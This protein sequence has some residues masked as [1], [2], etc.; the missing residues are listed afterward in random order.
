M[1][2][3]LVVLRATHARIIPGHTPCQY[4]SS[5]PLART[6][7]PHPSPL[8]ARHSPLTTHPIT[9]HPH[10]SQLAG[11]SDHS[12]MLE[13]NRFLDDIK[14]KGGRLAEQGRSAANKYRMGRNDGDESDEEESDDEEGGAEDPAAKRRLRDRERRRAAAGAAAKSVVN[15]GGRR[16]SKGVKVIMEDGVDEPTRGGR[17]RGGGGKLKESHRAPGKGGGRGKSKGARRRADSDSDSDSDSSGEGDSDSRSAKS[18]RSSGS[19]GSGDAKSGA[20][21]VM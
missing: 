4:P 6:L 9:P 15:G 14:K 8:A 19:G 5:V 17:G 16:R 10:Q 20:C 18:E 11:L 12:S 3:S 13:V 1:C 2:S 21:A 7:T